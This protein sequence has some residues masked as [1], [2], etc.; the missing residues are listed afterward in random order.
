MT[1]L[2][3]ITR[4]H[5]HSQR[6]MAQRSKYVLRHVLRKDPTIS[7]VEYLTNLSNESTRMRG[8]YLEADLLQDPGELRMYLDSRTERSHSILGVPR[9][10]D[11]GTTRR[12]CM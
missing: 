6:V 3:V 2:P 4:S 10:Q 1:D 8:R 7:Y 9:H 5:G 12:A 11:L